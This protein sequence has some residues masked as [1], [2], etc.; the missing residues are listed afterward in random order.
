MRTRVRLPP[1]VSTTWVGLEAETLD[2]QAHFA[3]RGGIGERAHLHH[4]ATGLRLSGR[5]TGLRLRH[6]QLLF[7]GL[8]GPA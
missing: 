8:G 6:G 5:S 2:L 4:E 7:G 3:R 1:S